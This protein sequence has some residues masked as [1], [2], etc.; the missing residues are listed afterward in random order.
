MNKF[1]NNI[2]KM[3]TYYLFANAQKEIIQSI[4]LT[5]VKVLQ[6]KVMNKPDIC[7]G[8]I[9]IFDNDSVEHSFILDYNKAMIQYTLL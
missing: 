4:K 6:I 5:L 8:I 9:E 7:F 3:K 1:N 2:S